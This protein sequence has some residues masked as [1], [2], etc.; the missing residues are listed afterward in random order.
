MESEII[1]ARM[2]SEGTADHRVK[3]LDG[4]RAIA[5]AGVI[6]QHAFG[7]LAWSPSSAGFESGAAGVRL[8]FVLSGFLITGILLRARQTACDRGVSTWTVW[9]AFYVRR[10]LRIL[11]LA[12]FALAVAW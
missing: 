4:L 8:F 10:A 12:Y 9:R 3:Q 11:P 7:F 5:V 6:V 2:R 1:D